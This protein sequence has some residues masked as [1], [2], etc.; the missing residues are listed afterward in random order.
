MFHAYLS[1]CRCYHTG[2][3]FQFNV[4][5]VNPYGRYNVHTGIYTVPYTGYYVFTWTVAAN[6]KSWFSAELRANGVL[7]G[8][9]MADS[10]V[11]GPSGIHPATGFV[12]AK[13][14]ANDH[15]YIRYV[16]GHG[17]G[18]KSDS[19]TRTTFTGWRIY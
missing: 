10:D 16:S 5:P 18:V 4:A 14:N 2:T 8:T 19:R 9:A 7:K 12:I 17:C 13:V 11:S 15:V 1:S 6:Y 3:T